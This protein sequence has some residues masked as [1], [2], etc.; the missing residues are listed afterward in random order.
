MTIEETK[1][2][3]DE[4]WE[5]ERFKGIKYK[6]H[7]YFSYEFRK[8]IYE[9]CGNKCFYCDL[10]LIEMNFTNLPQIDHIEPKCNGGT[11]DEWNLVLACRKCN[12]SKG[13]RYFFDYIKNPILCENLGRD[14]NGLLIFN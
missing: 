14:E 3:C 12:Q 8:Y 5:Q 13:G 9:S 1:K 4:V 11:N 10:P 7:R 6:E 2:Y